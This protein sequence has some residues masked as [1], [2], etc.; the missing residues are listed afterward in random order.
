MKIYKKEDELPEDIA[1]EGDDLIPE[2]DLPEEEE[3]DE[4]GLA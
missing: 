1:N 2:E 4:D 3:G